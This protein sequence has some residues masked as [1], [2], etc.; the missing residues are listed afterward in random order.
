MPLLAIRLDKHC[1]NVAVPMAA[2][3]AAEA[4]T[5][6][7]S[8]SSLHSN[9]AHDLA[10]LQAALSAADEGSILH[11]AHRTNVLPTVKVV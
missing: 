3:S 8:S 6:S 4:L 11:D 1:R 10:A 2:A 7:R 5:R 9:D